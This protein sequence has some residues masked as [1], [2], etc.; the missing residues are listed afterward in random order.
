MAGTPQQYR[1]LVGINY[2]PDNRRAEIGD[3]VNDLPDYAIDRLLKDGIIEKAEPAPTKAQQRK[4][5]TK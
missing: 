1:V 5:V 2:P 4:E 3:I